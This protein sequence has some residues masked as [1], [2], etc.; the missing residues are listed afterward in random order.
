M[1]LFKRHLREM[2][3]RTNR[4]LIISR[5]CLILLNAKNVIILS[6]IFGKTTKTI[7]ISTVFQKIDLEGNLHQQ[8]RKSK[9]LFIIFYLYM[10]FVGLLQQ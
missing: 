8:H 5:S 2:I 10:F 6:L 9:Y 7:V 4:A 3:G 1:I